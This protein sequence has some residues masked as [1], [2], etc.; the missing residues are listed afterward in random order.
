MGSA[1]TFAPSMPE[2]PA[3]ERSGA[4][5]SLRLC[6]KRK[7]G[8]GFPVSHS[9]GTNEYLSRNGT[10]VRRYRP[11]LLPPFPFFFL[12]QSIFSAGRKLWRLPLWA[13]MRTVAFCGPPLQ[14]C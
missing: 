5:A 2:A 7:P 9:M 14:R 3:R 8:K 11:L 13:A 10:Q 12:P 1:P 6:S 4:P